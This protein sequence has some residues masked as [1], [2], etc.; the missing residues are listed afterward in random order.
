MDISP[1]PLSATFLPLQC[2]LTLAGSGPLSNLVQNL[3]IRTR[4]R[5]DSSSFRIGSE[6]QV[7]L[8]RLAA[9]GAA[10]GLELCLF[11]PVDTVAKRL[12]V[13]RGTLTAANWQTVLL[14]DH[15]GSSLCG[16]LRSLFPGLGFGAVY[17]VTQRTYVWGGQ[18]V[19]KELLKSRYQVHEKIGKTLCDGLAGALMGAGEV[20]LLPLNA[21]KTKAQINAAHRSQGAMTVIR[22]H[23]LMKLYAG[24]QWTIARNVPGSFAFFG[25]SALVRHGVFGLSSQNEATLLHN[26]VA[27]AAGS[28]ASITVACPLDVVKTR[29][30]SGMFREQPGMSIAAGI[31]RENG[32]AGF[33]KGA[34]PKVA[35]VAPKMTFSFTV[36]QS[37][38][39]MAEQ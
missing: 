12:M 36:A 10:G 38:M 17:K 27:S 23:G 25:T 16:K 30:Q 34:L 15:A 13:S 19:M 33:F 20:V 29:I 8:S 35:A 37:L 14:Q 11:H 4:S 26:F 18:P 24:W 1:H 2:E 21:L 39:S 3:L 6:T 5:L 28:V 32:L 9:S 31:I 22:Q 7:V